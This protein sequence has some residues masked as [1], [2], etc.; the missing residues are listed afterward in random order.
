MK[1]LKLLLVL[2]MF[3]GVGSFAV[4]QETQAPEKPPKADSKSPAESEAPADSDQDDDTPKGLEKRQQESEKQKAD[5]E[6]QSDDKKSDDKKSDDKKSDYKKSDKDS[7]DKSSDDKDDKKPGSAEEEAKDLANSV[8]PAIRNIGASFAGQTNLSKRSD[9]FVELF[10]PV[11]ASVDDAT[12]RIM[13]G[14]HQIALG[15][16]VGSDGFI[17]TKYSELRGNVGCKLGDGT[18]VKADV[19]GIDKDTDLALLKIDALNLNEAPWSDQTAP[20]IGQWLATPKAVVRNKTDQPALGV[21]SVNARPIPPSRPFIGITMDDVEGGGGV[22]I[23]SVVDKSPAKFADLKRGD[24]ITKIEDNEIVDMKG[25][26][27]TLGQFDVNVRVTLSVT[28]NEKELKIKLTLAERDKISPENQRSL[29][30]NNMG[31]TPSK[32][33][34][35][36]PLA[37]QHD[38]G[39]NSNTCG[40]PIV[41]LSG[42]IV[43]INIARAGRVS[44]LALP[45]EAVRPIV[46]MLKTGD[47]SPA[48]VNKV[49]IEKID[50][51]LGELAE[52]VGTLPEK[53][54]VLQRKYGAE[55]ARLDEIERQIRELQTR[56]KVVKKRHDELKEEYDE[57]DDKLAII[58]KT[59]RKL[60]ADRKQMATGAR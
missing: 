56:L 33:R 40:G 13:S 28:R 53:R 37:F 18:I 21:V 15:T 41:D 2:L 25:L 20:L 49:D 48:K 4:A 14:K 52:R 55:R 29:T 10:D 1:N 43:G 32:R 36:F 35:D 27:E 17:L 45:V 50:L 16:V 3:V 26:R 58:E 47:Y 44:S 34:K 8:V 51:E 60:E 30:Q 42:R 22:K 59:R 6:K 31:S 9:S 19:Y 57:V 11:V 12:I 46:E 7:D 23:T 24:I 5:K 38:T 54:G 39:L